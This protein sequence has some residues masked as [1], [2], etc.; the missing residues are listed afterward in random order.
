MDLV[1]LGRLC[2]ILV[3]RRDVVTAIAISSMSLGWIC[4]FRAFVGKVAGIITIYTEVICLIL[5]LFDF[6]QLSQVY[7]VYIYGIFM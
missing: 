5:S 3:Y 1:D 6:G 7:G 4:L 2:W